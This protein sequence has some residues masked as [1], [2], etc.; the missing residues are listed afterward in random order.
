MR[1]SDC[2]RSRWT[3]GVVATLMT[4]SGCGVESAPPAGPTAPG[5]EGPALSRSTQDLMGNIAYGTDCS[6]GHQGFLNDVMRYGRVAAASNAFEQCVDRRVRERYR[7]CNGDP[8]YADSID[9]HINQVLWVARSSN[10]VRMNCTGGGGNASTNLGTYDHNNDEQ[11][12]WGGWMNSVYT[13]L[14]WPVCNGSNGPNC[15]FAAAPWPYSQAAGISW[16]EVMHTHGY[17]H[18]ANDQANA[19]VAC[20]YGSDTSWH[21]QVN[22]MPYII[23]ECLGE[24]IDLS[25]QRCGNVDS[26][27]PNALRIINGYDS[28]TCSCQ[29]DPR[30]RAMGLVDIRSEGTVESKVLEGERISGGWLY[31]NDNQKGW[32]GDY[33][34]DG[35]DDFILRSGW[36]LGVVTQSGTGM[37]VL[38]MYPY[39]TWLGSWP[40]WTASRRCWTSTAMAATS[41]C[42]AMTMEWPC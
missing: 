2:R 16:H 32:V 38:A 8:F 21:F 22:T 4:L 31:A 39:G 28:T 6:S 33:N 40:R 11:F 12:W 15:R 29:Y 30:P 10:P 25:G 42:S 36:G 20:G 14:S 27:G 41:W 5:E 35:R 26:C 18:G 3:A 9:T 19:K 23:G 17:T 7:K 24:I 37:S 1:E 34:G 13:Q